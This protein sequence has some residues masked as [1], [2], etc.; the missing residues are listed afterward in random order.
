MASLVL[1]GTQLMVLE[2]LEFVLTKHG[3]TVAA[4]EVDIS[5]M[6]RSVCEVHPDACLIVE[7]FSD[8]SASSA[9]TAVQGANGRSKVV[10]LSSD[11]SRCASELAIAAGASGYIHA[12]RTTDLVVASIG[13]VLSHDRVLVDVP[14]SET[15]T[16]AV[17]PA[18]E[19]AR[20]L[21]SHLTSR[22]WEVLTLIAEGMQTDAI[23]NK[24][25]ITRSTVRTY[26]ATVL[27]KLGV[28]NRLQAANLVWR[29]G[30]LT[31]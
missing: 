31:L 28:R 25:G 12:S 29:Y 3:F 20:R 6:L 2:A 15:R 7:P 27:C 19:E 10:V 24:L 8:V 18:V 16:R 26:V 9:V 22:E 4:L 23:A 30:L 13:H 14:A 21:A 5:G 1:G 17:D 11:G